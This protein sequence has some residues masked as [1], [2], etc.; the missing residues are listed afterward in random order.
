MTK[1]RDKKPRGTQ[2]ITRFRK[3]RFHG[4]YAD[5]EPKWHLAE[6]GQV[7]AEHKWGT[8]KALCGY[9]ANGILASVSFSVSTTPVARR[10]TCA[11]CLKIVAASGSK[12]SSE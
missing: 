9:T 6:T 4:K 8:T 2:E 5:V 12:A 1:D 7:L 11:K 3:T 10:T